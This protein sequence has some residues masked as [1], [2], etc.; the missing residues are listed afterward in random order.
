MFLIVSQMAGPIQIKLGTRVYFYPGIVLG[1][2]M[3]ISWPK[4]LRR[5]NGGAIGAKRDRGGVNA[6]GMS[7]E[8]AQV[9]PRVKEAG[10]PRSRSQCHICENGRTI[11]AEN[12][13]DWANAVGMRF[14]PFGERILQLVLDMVALQYQDKKRNIYFELGSLEWVGMKIYL[15]TEG[16]RN[17]HCASRTTLC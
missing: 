10:Q 4:C 13:R 7:I 5:E 15:L 9:A 2:S 12:D 3:S 1:M 14:A 11:V 16:A 17:D 6:V 8:V